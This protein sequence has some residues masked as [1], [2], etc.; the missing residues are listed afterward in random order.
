MV[1]SHLAHA[2]THA[3]HAPN[4]VIGTWQLVS[5]VTHTS[6][7]GVHQPYGEHP[8][9][10]VVYTTDGHVF[11]QIMPEGPRNTRIVDPFGGTSEE[12]WRALGYA[13][14]AGRYEMHNDSVVHQLEMCLF[15]GLVGTDLN[16][17]MEWGGDRLIL[18]T[19]PTSHG[20]VSRFSRL[21]WERLPPR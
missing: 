8:T 12:C 5:C 15:P 21:T 7:G 3:P 9:G 17:S 6:D 19:R 10:Y 11:V 4:D 13:A 18:T 14:Y 16:R 20:G 2:R 1:S